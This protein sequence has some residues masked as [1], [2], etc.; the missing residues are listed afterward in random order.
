MARSIQLAGGFDTSFIIEGKVPDP[1]KWE[2]R[3]S[4]RCRHCGGHAHRDPS[5]PEI[6]GCPGNLCGYATDV[7][8]HFFRPLFLIEEEEQQKTAATD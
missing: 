4:F 5:S 3:E 6:Y 7:L 1:E 8:S 2:K